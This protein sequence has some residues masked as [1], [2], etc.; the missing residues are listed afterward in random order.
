MRALR[1][2]T[3][4]AADSAAQGVPEP[5]KE[6]QED[7][8]NA[9]IHQQ[10][11]HEVV[12]EEQD[13]RANDRR[14]ER[15]HVHHRDRSSVHTSRLLPRSRRPFDER[16]APRRPPFRRGTPRSGG[17]ARESYVP[18]RGSSVPARGVLGRGTP[19]PRGWPC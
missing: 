19:R 15:K 11:R 3:V 6:G 16:P 13:I 5:Q 10:P 8:D 18:T 17:P 14:R 1:R 7:Q 2:P 12:S 9:D 4:A